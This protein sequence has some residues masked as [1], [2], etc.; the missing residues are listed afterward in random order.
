[1]PKPALARQK[2]LPI[3]AEI[4][5]RRIYLIR[6]QKVMV[7]S[8]LEQLYQVLTKNLNLAVRR[9]SRR[10][11]VSADLGRNRFFE[12]ANCNLKK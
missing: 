12:V 8:D 3:P 4:I 7:D 10:L 1:M 5:E 6:S 11:Y 2:E 9:N